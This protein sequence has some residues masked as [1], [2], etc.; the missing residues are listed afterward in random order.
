LSAVPGSGKDLRQYEEKAGSA[1]P[2]YEFKCMKCDEFIEI[3]VMSADDPNVEMKCK[4]CGSEELERVMSRTHYAMGANA[5]QAASGPSVQTR[6]CSAGSCSTI[7][8]PGHT[9]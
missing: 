3:L 2:I 6:N 1:M 7:E 9:R 4:K 8:L 5:S